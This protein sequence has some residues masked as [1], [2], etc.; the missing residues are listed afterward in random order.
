MRVGPEAAK[1]SPNAENLQC[2]FRTDRLLA[3]DRDELQLLALT[4]SP[5]L[6][7]HFS[8]PFVIPSLFVVH[9]L[10]SQGSQWVNITN[11]SNREES[12][13]REKNIDRFVQET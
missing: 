5:P 9:S 1:V 10:S 6:R 13:E 12:F 2:S 11:N 3:H 8:K 4:A 7:P